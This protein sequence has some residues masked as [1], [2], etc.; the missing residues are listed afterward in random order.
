M[1]ASALNNFN[2]YIGVEKQLSISLTMITAE[3]VAGTTAPAL[4]KGHRAKALF[5]SAT[6]LQNAGRY[7]E[8]LPPFEES[9][10][11]YES[12]GDTQ[13]SIACLTGLGCVCFEQ[14]LSE[15]ALAMARHAQSLNPRTISAFT[16]LCDFLT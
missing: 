5:I 7:S 8:C 9:L 6:S 10:A 16:H 1:A 13:N 14:G 15:K 3:A 12:I 11:Y 4:L 2:D